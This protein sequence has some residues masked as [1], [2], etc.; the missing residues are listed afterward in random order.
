MRT[1]SEIANDWYD[2]EG[3]YLSIQHSG[4]ENRIASWDKVPDDVYSREFARWLT[5]QYRLAMV[6]GIEFGR[7]GSQD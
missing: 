1:P 2:E 6:K 4:D 5:R 3:I 7:S